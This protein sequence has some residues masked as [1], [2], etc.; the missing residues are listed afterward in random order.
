M[1]NEC[2][3]YVTGVGIAEGWFDACMSWPATWVRLNALNFGAAPV[4]I[5]P[6]GI[7]LRRD[8]VEQLGGLEA[9]QQ[10]NLTGFT[11]GMR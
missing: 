1:L 4:K 6:A 10:S 8:M 5:P 2:T 9:A 11:V 3:V 7:M